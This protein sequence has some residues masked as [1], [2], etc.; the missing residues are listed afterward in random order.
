MKTTILLRFFLIASLALFG[1]Q[2]ALAVPNPSAIVWNGVPRTF[3]TS[4]YIGVLGRQ[5]E[6]Q[7]VVTEWA[8]QVNSTGH[9]RYRVFWAFINSPEYQA[10]PWAKQA[11]EYTVYR[12]YIMQNNSYSYSVSKHISDASYY[13][14]AGPYTFGVAMAMRDYYMTFERKR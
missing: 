9:S 2:I 4:L 11:R 7:R 14:H 3:V 1:F 10:S 5:P 6:N 12:R 8:A 13:I